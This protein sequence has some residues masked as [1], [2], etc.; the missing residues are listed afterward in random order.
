MPSR[1]P[2]VRR[3]ASEET[4]CQMDAMF[5]ALD[6]NGDSTVTPAEITRQMRL[7]GYT[8]SAAADLRDVLDIDGDGLIT[9]SSSTAFLTAG[10]RPTLEDLITEVSPPS[11][12]NV[13]FSELKA[14]V[15]RSGEKLPPAC[16]ATLKDHRMRGISLPHLRAA[17]EHAKRRCAAE[18]WMDFY[19]NGISPTSFNH[20]DLVSRVLAP[21]TRVDQCSFAEF[22]ASAPQRPGWMVVHGWG[23]PV[24]D[25]LASLDQHTVDLSKVSQL[26][27]CLRIRNGQG[28]LV[29]HEQLLYTR[30]ILPIVL[31]VVDSSAS[32]CRAS[33]LFGVSTALN[34]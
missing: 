30:S 7:R 17:C 1:A 27:L 32:S 3:R 11:K 14:G 29:K 16:G 4:I 6:E 22:V 13:R 10:I 28:Q 23:E 21:A 15:L 34:A 26:L 18:S 8:D 24:V 31:C 5:N 12:A 19:G 2:R 9:L 25:F 20:Y 33:A